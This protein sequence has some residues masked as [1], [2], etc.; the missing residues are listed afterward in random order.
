MFYTASGKIADSKRSLG[1]GLALCKAIV[2]AH[3]GMITVY[4]NKPKGS[5]FDFTIPSEEVLIQE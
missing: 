3:G 4:N 1:L 2:E 5:V